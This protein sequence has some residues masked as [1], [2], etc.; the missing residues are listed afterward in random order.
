M[1]PPSHSHGPQTLSIG[2]SSAFNS[3]AKAIK[4]NGFTAPPYIAFPIMSAFF[5]Y[6]LWIAMN[7]N[8][9]G[10]ILQDTLASGKYADGTTLA[11]SYTGIRP[12]D[13]LITMVVAFEYPVTNGQDEASWLLMLD[14][15]STLQ[16]AIL[17]VFMDSMRKGR[18]SKWFA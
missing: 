6:Y 13:Q 3:L 12:L 2:P 8:G 15:M 1:G 16:T 5:T 18:S 14:I 7:F 4:Q 17:W 9:T 11:L 10:D